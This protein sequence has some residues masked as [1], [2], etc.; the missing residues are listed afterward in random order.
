MWMRVFAHPQGPGSEVH[1]QTQGASDVG[2]F[3]GWRMLI[4]SAVS[5]H[6]RLQWGCG[7]RETYSLPCKV[8]G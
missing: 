4:M 6:P 8:S 2:S 3:I 5:Q 1:S 7:M